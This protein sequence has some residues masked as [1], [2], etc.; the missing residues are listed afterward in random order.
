[1]IHLRK[2]VEQTESMCGPATLVSIL[3]FYG[4]KKSEKALSRLCNSSIKYGTDP[5]DI[6]AGLKRLGFR[7]KFRQHGTWS[8]L[9][10][11]TEKKGIPVLVNWWYDYELPAEGHYSAVYKV[12][13]RFIYM[14]DPAIGDYRRMSK[15]K[16]LRNWYDYIYHGRGYR[17]NIRWYLYIAGGV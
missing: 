12:T 11:L 17:K 16:F 15:K 7:V 2:K 1:M 6:I 3:D 9:Q 5:K 10:K 14:M 8:E 4:I 13:D